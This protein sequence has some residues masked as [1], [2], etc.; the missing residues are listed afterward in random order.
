MASG[1]AADEVNA[2]E[3]ELQQHS[4]AT[5]TV[6]DKQG[7][8]SERKLANTNTNGVQQAATTAGRPIQAEAS[9]EHVQTVLAEDASNDTAGP[10]PPRPPKPT[11]PPVFTWRKCWCLDCPPFRYT[12]SNDA[13]VNWARKTWGDSVIPKGEM[14]ITFM[15]DSTWTRGGCVACGQADPCIITQ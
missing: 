2:M 14:T 7:R 11:P 12:G 4:Q 8:I 10:R 3:Q 9:A 15:P 6:I 1:V 13:C 5:I